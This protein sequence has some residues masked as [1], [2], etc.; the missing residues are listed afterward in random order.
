MVPE[1]LLLLELGV[2]LLLLLMMMMMMMIPLRL[3]A[4]CERLMATDS[5][6]MSVLGLAAAW[7][8]TRH[9]VNRRQEVEAAAA[10]MSPR[11]L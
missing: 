6:A 5:R 2:G 4:A 8:G 3:A 11:A 9:I 10:A 1:L 7:A